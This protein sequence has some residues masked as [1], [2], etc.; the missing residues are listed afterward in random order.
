MTT[1]PQVRLRDCMPDDLPIFFEQQRDPDA[2]HMAAFAASN[3]HDYSAFLARWTRLLHNPNII[4]RTILA[5]ERIAGHLSRFQQM[6]QPSVGY[7]LGKPFWGQGIATQALSLYLATDAT[8]PLYARV[9][10]DNHGSRRVLEKCGF[11]VT[12]QARGYANTRGME[13]DELILKLE[14]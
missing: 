5:D 4:A 10:S 3:P 7:W 2:N 14:A 1:T 8:R 11:V 9:A 6:G 12:G 13:I